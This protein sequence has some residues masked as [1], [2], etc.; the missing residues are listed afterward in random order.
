MEAIIHLKPLELTDR[1]QSSRAVHSCLRELILNGSFPP[2][3][4]LS[5][6]ELSKALG[7][8]RTPLREAFRMLQEEGLIEAEPNLRARVSLCS[9][10]DLATVYASRIVLESLGIAL[11][12]SKFSQE[13]KIAAE[14]ALEQMHATSERNNFAEWQKAHRTFHCILSSHAG[15]ELSRIIQTL[16]ERAERYFYVYRP[17]NSRVWW[18]HASEIE[19]RQ[20]LQACMQHSSNEAARLVARHLAAFA[21]TILTELE[22]AHHTGAI[23]T[24]LQLVENKPTCDTTTNAG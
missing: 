14:E 24:A 5:Q 19:H 12:A 20:L 21:N 10:D 17:R 3:A 7:V 11:T 23:Q 15:Q 2:G 8:S 6:L 18:S 13:Q 16:I 9:P 22:P 4:V 1:R